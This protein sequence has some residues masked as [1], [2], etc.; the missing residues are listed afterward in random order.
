MKGSISALPLLSKDSLTV[1]CSHLTQ[2]VYLIKNL[3]TKVRG[4]KRKHWLQNNQIQ[5]V[6]TITHLQDTCFLMLN[7]NS[8]LRM[9]RININITS[10]S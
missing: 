10:Y 8:I 9:E 1:K 3:G 6:L 5:L 4:V 7:F 2:G